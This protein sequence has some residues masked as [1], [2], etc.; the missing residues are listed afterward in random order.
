MAINVEYFSTLIDF[1]QNLEF[2]TAKCDRVKMVKLAEGY[3]FHLFLGEREMLAHGLDLK[4]AAFDA[5]E[6][7]K[8]L[9]NKVNE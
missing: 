7:I 9:T 5:V 4:S 1:E 8:G 6:Q 2:V 3:S